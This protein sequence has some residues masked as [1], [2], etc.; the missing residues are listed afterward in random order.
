M[1]ERGDKSWTSN[2]A[3]L[4]LISAIAERADRRANIREFQNATLGS[5]R[6]FLAI[7]SLRQTLRKWRERIQLQR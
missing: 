1:D 5:L 3:N 4:F 2:F 7:I 6:S